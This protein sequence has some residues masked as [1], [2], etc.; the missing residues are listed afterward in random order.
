MALVPQNHA[1]AHLQ[2]REDHHFDPR[3]LKHRRLGRLQ[4]LLLL[5]PVWCYHDFAAIGFESVGLDNIQSFQGAI[6]GHRALGVGGDRALFIDPHNPFDIQHKAT[7]GVHDVGL[8]VF[9]VGQGEVG[10][11]GTGW[12]RQQRADRDCQHT[13]QA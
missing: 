1:I 5:D 7:V 12:R 6:V 9:F 3:V 10:V 13:E 11:I 2:L 8:D 4:F